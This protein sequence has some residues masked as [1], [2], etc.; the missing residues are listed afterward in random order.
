MK[1]EM[2]PKKRDA[3]I[4]EAL[5]IVRDQHYFVPLHYQLRPWAMKKNVSTVY[6]A[7][8]APESRFAR[9]D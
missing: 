7:N 3:L 5:V 8:D 1:T 2:D 4:Q 9:V 6:R